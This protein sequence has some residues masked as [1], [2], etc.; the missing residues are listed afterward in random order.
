MANT[1]PC[2]LKKCK[3]AIQDCPDCPYSKEEKKKKTI[4]KRTGRCQPKK[5]KAI[6]CI[7]AGVSNIGP[8]DNYGYKEYYKGHGFKKIKL[9]KDLCFYPYNLCKFWKKAGAVFIKRSLWFARLFP[10]AQTLNFTSFAKS[11]VAL[12]DL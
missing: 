2:R 3:L 4:W 12:T 10:K 5:C 9:G 1:L 11:L 6:C 8:K 7:L